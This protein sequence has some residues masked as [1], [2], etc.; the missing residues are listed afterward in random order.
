MAMENKRDIRLWAAHMKQWNLLGPPLRPA[1]EDLRLFQ[2]EIDAWSA[3]HGRHAA[4]GLVLGVTPEL[5]ALDW[6]PGSR[7]F[8]ADSSMEMIG[9][10]WYLT[11]P[12]AAG[13]VATRW[14]ELPFREASIDL[15]MGDGCLTLCEWPAGYTQFCRA[16]QRVLK[17]GGRLVIRVHVRPDTPESPAHVIAELEAGRIAGFNAFKWR[18]LVALHGDGSRGIRLGDAWDYWHGLGLGEDEL[19]ERH[20]W[21]AASIRTIHAYRDKDIVYFFPRVAEIS[22]L[23]APHFSVIACHRPAY[24]AAD[25]HR[26]FVLERPAG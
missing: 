13:A 23:F 16:V 7:V 5:P 9:F 11:A 12:F 8:A 19:A 1:A 21:P 3:A 26:V 2:R 10:V 15:A 17:P 6:P 4:T 18:L 25:E 22:E 14:Q 24:D 20:G